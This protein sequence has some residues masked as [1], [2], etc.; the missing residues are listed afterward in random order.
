LSDCQH[1]EFT[2]QVNV[3]RLTAEDGAVTGYMAEFRVICR[4]CGRPFQFLGLEPGV[5]NQ[6]ARVSLDGLEANIGICPQGELPSPLDRMI[7]NFGR[8]PERTN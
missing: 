5:D 6:G 4:R 7:V 3:A 8:A 2:A 1:E